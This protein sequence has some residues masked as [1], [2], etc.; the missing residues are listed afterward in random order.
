MLVRVGQVR[1]KPRIA[2]LL[3]MNGMHPRLAAEEAFLV[4]EREGVVLAALAYRVRVRRLTLGVLTRRRAA[5]R[6]A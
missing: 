5:I 4:V 2:D 6:G 1:D 3:Q